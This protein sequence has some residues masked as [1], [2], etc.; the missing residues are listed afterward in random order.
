MLCTSPRCLHSL[1]SFICIDVQLVKLTV[2]WPGR[3]AA[4]LGSPLHCCDWETS[5][6]TFNA[7]L[8][9]AHHH[10]PMIF[11]KLH[12]EGRHDPSAVAPS[13]LAKSVRTQ[14]VARGH[15]EC[16]LERGQ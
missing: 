9:A 11:T 7:R 6:K 5:L 2:R 15:P 13:M 3:L 8:R 12:S 1:L 16:S 4:H 10:D 14:V